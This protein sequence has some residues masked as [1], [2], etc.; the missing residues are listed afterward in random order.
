MFVSCLLMPIDQSKTKS[1]VDRLFYF[2]EECH[3][4]FEKDFIEIIQI[5]V[6]NMAISTILILPINEHGRSFHLLVSSLISFFS[7]IYE[8][9]C[10]YMWVCGC[11]GVCV[12]ERERERERLLTS[13]LA[14]FLVYVFYAKKMSFSVCLLL[15]HRRGFT[16]CISF[17]KTS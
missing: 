2:Y 16:C 12:C 13:W 3:W 10:A 15:V 8:R 1:M 14:L 11:V 4:N 17:K 5:A 9:L 7:D 6:I